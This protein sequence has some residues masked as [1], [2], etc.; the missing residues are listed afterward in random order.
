M[1]HLGPT[2]S[3]LKLSWNSF[4]AS[5]GLSWAFWGHVGP[6]WEH[7]GTKSFLET[8]GQIVLCPGFAISGFIS[9]SKMGYFLVIAGVI[10]WTSFWTISGQL[11][12]LFWGPFWD[13]IGTR[14]GQE[15]PKRAVKDL[16][17]CICENLKNMLFF[18][19]FE[20]RGHPR[21]PQ[22]AQDSS[23]EAPKELQKLNK[24]GSRNGPHNYYLFDQFWGIVLG[25]KFT[26]TWDQKWD[27]F[28]N[29]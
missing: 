15:K 3:I 20:V 12:G 29:P 26:P 6:S 7:L 2:C 22:K 27:Q 18:N 19:L 5:A 9:G 24:T 17:T 28:W 14:R 1:P 4:W 25:S 8:S 23:Q 16:K 10:C 11:L 21:Q 13:Q